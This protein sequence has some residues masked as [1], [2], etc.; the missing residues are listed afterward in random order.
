[1]L[2]FLILFLPFFMFFITLFFISL[3]FLILLFLLFFFLHFLLPFFLDLLALSLTLLRTQW[4]TPILL[5]FTAHNRQVWERLFFLSLFGLLLKRFPLIPSWR[6]TAPVSDSLI[7]VSYDYILTRIVWNSDFSIGNCSRFFGRPFSKLV[8]SLFEHLIK[9]THGCSICCKKT[10]QK[11]KINLFSSILFDLLHF[12][13]TIILLI[14]LINR[15]FLYIV[16][17]KDT[18]F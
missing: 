6:N 8:A 12:V 9:H 14:L 10:M 5:C 3:F 16:S 18:N 13:V 15:P 1:M 7:K 11:M 2:S 4:I 17:Q